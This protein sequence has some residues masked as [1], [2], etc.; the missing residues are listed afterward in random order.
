MISR[1][2]FMMVTGGFF[3]RRLAAAAQP[4]GKPPKVG[5]LLLGM[6]EA[7]TTR[8]AAALREGLRE[9]GWIEGQNIL[10]E[11]RYASGKLYRARQLDELVPLAVELV[12][13]K[14]DAIVAFGTVA[15]LA[16][17][18]A[19]TTIPI[20]MAAA[21][22]PVGSNLVA[23]LAQP[24]G[25]V[26]GVTLDVLDQDLDAKRLEL[27]KETLPKVSRVAVSYT[28][29]NENNPSHQ[30][31][32]SRMEAVAPTLGI[33]LRL[34]ALGAAAE[35]LERTFA[36]MRRARVGALRLQSDPVTDQWCGRI[37]E[38]A[39]KHRLPTMFDMR[40][41]VEAG[42]LMSYAPSLADIH[43]RAA[44]YVHKILKGANPADLPVE[45]PTKF[46]MVINLKT[47]KALG[48]RIPR[49]VL[50]RADEVIQ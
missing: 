39:I 13:Q 5:L 23:N 19:T 20:V 7:D 35:D 17:H 46:E 9:L 41:Y 48:L 14:V 26:T 10:L 24:G 38:L 2:M 12:Q 4:S 21:Q 37:A 28:L 27:L 29:G 34:V 47:A 36:L 15:S 50:D 44:T 32:M 42:G 45:Q 25:N 1:R 6:P 33:E 31:Q 30:R 43:R 18:Q 49:S 16:A 11:Y 8:R 3:I 40:L 22:D